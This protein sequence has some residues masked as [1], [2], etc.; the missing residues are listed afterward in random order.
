M[1]VSPKMNRF[2]ERLPLASDRVWLRY[3]A[4]LG[5]SAIALALRFALVP[6]IPT[7]FPFATFLPAAIIAA[8]LFGLG[9]GLLAAALCS[10]AARSFFLPPAG[11]WLGYDPEVVTA[12]YLAVTGLAIVMIHGMQ[13]TTANLRIERQ[14]SENYAAHADL[15][16]HELQHR[17]SNNLQMIGSVLS[18]QR[19]TVKDPAA[20]KALGDAVAKLQT[21]GRIQRQL[22]HPNG[23][24]L[25]LDHFLE[26]L[27]HDLIDAG[28]RSGIECNVQCQP[29]VQLEPHAAIPVALVMAE[30]VANSVEHGFAD[31]EMG[32]IEIRVEPGKGWLTLTVA[33]DGAG[34]PAGFNPAQSSSLGLK[35][36]RSLAEQLGGTFTLTAN[37]P[38][39]TVARLHFPVDRRAGH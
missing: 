19:R 1:R 3:G 30:A 9:P 11:V 35:I 22:Y 31:R 20:S 38:L 14:R 10:V 7:G 17:V 6:L 39:G 37:A 2:L 26:D 5:V 29:G 24:H 28:A 18:L 21:I 12:G 27:A 4:A 8:F 15:L 34:L 33:D 25:A 23:V 36:A 13:R 16:F 32:R